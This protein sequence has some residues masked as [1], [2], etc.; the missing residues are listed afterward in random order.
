MKAGSFLLSILGVSFAVLLEFSCATSDAAT[1]EEYFSLGSAYLD[2][3]KYAEAER[4]FQKARAADK[5]RNASEYNLGRIA[6]ELGRTE[7]AARIFESL[8]EK[9]GENATLLRAAAYARIK[10]GDYEKAV[11]FYERAAALLPETEDSGYNFALVLFATERYER[12]A[13][14]LAKVLAAESEDQDA[15]LLLAR[16]RKALNRPEAIDSYEAW[17][18]VKDDAAVRRELAEACGADA[19]PAKEGR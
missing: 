16:T 19:P 1:A 10:N 8:L 13:D 14:I 2:L 9:D 3:G 17:L 6:F 15:L 12:A 7:E 4:W 11:G 18:A 5:T